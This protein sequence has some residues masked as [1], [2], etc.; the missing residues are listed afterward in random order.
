MCVENLHAKLYFIFL[1]L[2]RGHNGGPHH[3]LP[4]SAGGSQRRTAAGLKPAVQRALFARGSAATRAAPLQSRVANGVIIAPKRQRHPA[5]VDGGLPDC[6]V[7]F[8]LNVELGVVV[9]ADPLSGTA[10]AIG[11]AQRALIICA[12]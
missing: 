5:G 11:A 6:V 3:D 8:P 9:L 4:V 7:A 12:A 1:L 2:I 10:L